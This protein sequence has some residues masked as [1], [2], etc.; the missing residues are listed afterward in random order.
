M[1][2]TAAVASAGR[3][4]LQECGAEGER[5][6]GREGA[7]L[8][9]AGQPDA[10]LRRRERFTGR[11]GDEQGPRLRGERLR[12]ALGVAGQPGRVD[13]VRGGLGRLSHAPAPQLAWASTAP[14]GAST[15]VLP[16]S[17]AAASVRSRWRTAS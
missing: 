5:G 4:R 8:E 2:R 10:L 12:D 3:P 14:A 15:N 1:A 17:C 13:R 9:L 7:R 6:R 16:V 11:A